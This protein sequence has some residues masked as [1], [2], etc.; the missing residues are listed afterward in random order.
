MKKPIVKAFALLLLLWLS[1]GASASAETVSYSAIDKSFTFRAPSGFQATNK[2]QGAILDLE[3][4]GTGV[5]LVAINGK[6]V[7]VELET[8]ASQ[9]K[10]NIN[11][12]GGSV[13]GSVDATLDGQ[14]AV[15]FLVAGIKPGK[16][17]FFVYNLRKDAVYTFV[18]NY[19]KGS[20][21]EAVKVWKELAPT[22]KFRP[23]KKK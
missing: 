22:L 16:E 2:A 9:M 10:M 5:S 20:R 14:P 6:A 18:F 1:A 23:T 17:S 3:I 7:E 19:P 15:S 13:L 4:P 21:S 11:D 8:F 12:A